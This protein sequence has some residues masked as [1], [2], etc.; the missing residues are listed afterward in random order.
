MRWTRVGEDEGQAAGLYR[1][2]PVGGDVYEGLLIII[3]C[4]ETSR[5]FT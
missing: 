5:S 1:F 4:D 2:A 3:L